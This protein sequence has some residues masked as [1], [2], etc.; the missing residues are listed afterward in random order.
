VF[1]DHESEAIMPRFTHIICSVVFLQRTADSY[2]FQ[3]MGG[4]FFGKISH[5]KN[6]KKFSGISFSGICPFAKTI[7]VNVSRESGIGANIQS[8]KKLSGN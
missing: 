7:R 3:S 5:R 8:G 1:A 6:E 2:W 4:Y